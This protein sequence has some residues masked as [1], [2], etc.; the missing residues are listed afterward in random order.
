MIFY[1]SGVGGMSCYYMKKYPNIFRAMLLPSA[2]KYGTHRHGYAIDNGAFK[3]WIE[4]TPWNEKPFYSILDRSLKWNPSDFVVLPDIVGGGLS[5]IRLSCDHLARVKS[6]GYPIYLPIQD[7]VPLK[8]LDWKTIPNT[9]SK[10][11][12]EIDGVFLGGT[13]FEFKKSI[14][15]QLYN[16][17]KD[18]GL[19]FHI[20]KIGTKE[21]LEWA[22]SVNAD[23]VDSSS[24]SRART[25]D[26]L[27]ILIK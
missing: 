9:H 6:Y 17:A 11:Y 4:K 26:I 19:K 8:C 15:K 27:D 13:T 22:I 23:S 5:S 3:S 20:G 25:W 18:R 12:E 16:I 21:K 10:L 2:W 14:G 24:I 7:N 1:F